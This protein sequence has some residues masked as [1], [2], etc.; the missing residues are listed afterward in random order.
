MS[1]TE[2]TDSIV[3]MQTSLSSVLPVSLKFCKKILAKDSVQSFFL[4]SEAH[5]LPS[6]SI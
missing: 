3:L 6:Y 5:N 4:H 2:E 1:Y